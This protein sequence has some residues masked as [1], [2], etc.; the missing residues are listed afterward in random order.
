MSDPYQATATDLAAIREICERHGFC[1]IKG[2]LSRGD[3]EGLLAGMRAETQAGGGRVTSDLLGLPALRHIYFDPRLLAIARA[4]LGPQ[5]VYDGEGN[6]NFEEAIGVNTLNPYSR[7]HCDA[8]GMPGDI[9]HT[10]SSPTDAVYRGYRFGIYFQDYRRASGA[11]K[12]VAGSHRGDPASYEEAQIFTGALES[13][14]IGRH[15]IECPGV[16]YPLYNLPSEPGDVVVWNLRTFHSAGA[17]LFIDNPSLAVHPRV[18]EDIS[19]EAPSLFAPPPGPRNALFFDYASP[20]EE[21]DLYIKLRARPTT[22]GLEGRLERRSDDPAALELARSHGVAVRHDTLIAGLALALATNNGPNPVRKLDAAAI[23]VAA[24]RLH[25]LASVHE[26]YSPYFPLFNRARFGAA[27][28]R[29]AALA[30]L[31]DDI[32]ATAL[33]KAS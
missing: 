19:A 5:L 11:L 4:L 28:T 24:A 21:I 23:E 17:K 2:V 12:V 15:R 9:T 18:E 27:G 29:N 10:W 8:K 3:L 26:E 6:V 16:R 25:R 13:H 32:L 14:L 7:L 20:C 22:S 1:L 33:V 31:I 30:S